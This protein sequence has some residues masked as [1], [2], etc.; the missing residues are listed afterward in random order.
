MGRWS[1]F[2][3]GHE[4]ASASP[5]VAVQQE[6]T[7]KA[8]DVMQCG[9]VTVDRQ[10]SVYKAI[11]ILAEKRISG[12]PVVDGGRL[13]GMLSEKDVLRSL[14]QAESLLGRVEEY[15]TPHVV[16]FD[17]EAPLSDIGQ[18]LI[19]TGF[20]RVAVLQEGRLAGI[21]TRADL[22]RHT[23][24][25]LLSLAERTDG[26]TYGP[27]VKD[28]MQHGLLTVK[29]KTSLYEAADLLATRCVTGLPV[30]DDSMALVGI[31]TEKDILKVLFDPDATGQE[32]QDLMTTEVVSFAP[33]DSLVNVCRCLIQHDFHRV[34]ILDGRRLVG[35]ISCTDIMLHMLK[36]KSN[37]FRHWRGNEASAAGRPS[38]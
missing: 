2:R 30:V 13:V 24:Y 28:V 10:E 35:I 3:S 31:I 22:I 5:A 18:T 4:D 27:L 38:L 26:N 6:E 29:N 16:S 15:M 19:S 8:R 9:V 20:R 32:V 37:V 12:L 25:R 23:K 36:N 11:G 17:L 33:A 7:P 34:P 1:T 14:C 21:I